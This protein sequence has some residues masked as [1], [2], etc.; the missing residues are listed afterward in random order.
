MP[1]YKENTRIVEIYEQNW[2]TKIF[3]VLRRKKFNVPPMGVCLVA[4]DFA[5]GRHSE[6]QANIFFLQ[7]EVL[8]FSKIG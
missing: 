8:T 5:C 1:L 4:Y 3:A 6:G 7:C 2:Q